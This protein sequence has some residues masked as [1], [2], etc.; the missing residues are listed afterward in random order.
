MFYN[1][2]NTPLSIYFSQQLPTPPTPKYLLKIQST[3][4]R[5][6]QTE[7]TLLSWRTFVIALTTIVVDV[8]FCVEIAGKVIFI[9]RVVFIT[10]VAFSIAV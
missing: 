8:N 6:T 1:K 2:T 3:I 10:D 7:N 9:N 5:W 4:W